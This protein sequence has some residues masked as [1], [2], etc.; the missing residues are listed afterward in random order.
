MARQSVSGTQVQEVAERIKRFNAAALNA[1]TSKV[2]VE[3]FINANQSYDL[4]RDAVEKTIRTVI[5]QSMG[6][7]V[8]N[9][10]AEGQVTQNQMEMAISQNHTK[11][12]IRA[13]ANIMAVAQ[14]GKL[15]LEQYHKQAI[16]EVGPAS[17]GVNDIGIV[18]VGSY[19]YN[20]M[21]AGEY[22]NNNAE[23][24]KHVG[25]SIDFNLQAARQNDEWEHMFPTVTLDPSEIGMEVDINLLYVHQQVRH[26]MNRK[27][28]MPY[29]RRNIM[30]AVTDPTVFDDN[31]IKFHPYF[32]EDPAG[33]YREYFVPET[34]KQ[35]TF[36]VSDSHSVR[37]NPL[38]FGTGEKPLLSLSAHPGSTSATSRDETDEFDPRFRMQDLFVLISG[39]AQD[40]AKDEGQLVHFSTLNLPKSAFQ[41]A[42]EGNRRTLLLHFREARFNLTGARKDVAGNEV[43]AL[44]NVKD[45]EYMVT[46]TVEVNAEINLQD[47]IEKHARAFLTIEKVYDKDGTEIDTK[48]GPGKTLLESFKLTPYAYN[49]AATLS[50]ANRRSRGTLLDN[51]AEA[52]RYKTTLQS[53]ITMQKPVNS[54]AAPEESQVAN[55]ILAARMRN[56][57]QAGTKLLNYEETLAEVYAGHVN[58]YEVASIEGVGRWYVHPWYEKKTFDALEQVAALQSSDIPGQLRVAI[59]NMLRDQVNRAFLESRFEPAL[60]VYSKYTVNRPTIGI[61]TDPVLRNWLWMQGDTRALGDGFN[62]YIDHTYDE[63]FRDTIRWYFS[64]TTEGFHALHFG[65]FLWVSEL[66]TATSMSRDSRIADELTVQPRCEHIVNCPIM[67]RVDVVNLSKF[68]VSQGGIVTNAKTALDDAI[69]EEEVPVGPTPGQP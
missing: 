1:G 34:L 13:A 5:G 35:P 3:N 67:G 50:N 6:I 25:A 60:Q 8:G 46:F 36:P 2:G 52:E 20:S 63:R 19:G 69:D 22:F 43:V 66:V 26:A 56:N 32:K 4:G 17:K 11:A 38:R 64:T 47:G 51:Q 21:P 65:A 58:K 49:W 42:Q 57:A 68:V 28:N 16:A 18:Q 31:T 39:Q 9:E 30:D 15:G 14:H 10:A 29:K 59:L 40:P 37:T 23:L 62:Y 27:D 12:Q 24:D 45:G 61:L 48:S 33:D 55:L 54:G 44:S 41:L 7:K 53:P